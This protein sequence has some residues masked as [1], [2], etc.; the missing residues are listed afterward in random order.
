MWPGL[1]DAVRAAS[2]LSAPT[3]VLTG[4]VDAVYDL[5]DVE[6]DAIGFVL[7]DDTGYAYLN[8]LLVDIRMAVI[9][10]GFILMKHHEF[11]LLRALHM[12][13]NARHVE[14]KWLSYRCRCGFVN[15]GLQV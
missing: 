4:H 6:I 8:A 13:A 12:L 11:Q 14:H 2:V 9:T 10:D 5:I 15:F 7:D 3:V 1:P